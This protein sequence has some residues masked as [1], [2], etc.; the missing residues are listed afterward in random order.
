ML[1]GLVSLLQNPQAVLEHGQMILDGCKNTQGI[2][3]SLMLQES[4]VQVNL[5]SGLESEEQ[6]ELL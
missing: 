6:T 1:Q 5:E 3:D 4:T 2:L